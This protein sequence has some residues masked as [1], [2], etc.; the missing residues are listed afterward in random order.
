MKAIAFMLVALISTASLA[1]AAGPGRAPHLGIAV[2]FE[3]Q[4]DIQVVCAFDITDLESG[5]R[6]LAPRIVTQR[7]IDA[8]LTSTMSHADRDLDVEMRCHVDQTQAAYT[9]SLRDNGM[10]LLRQ[11]GSLD[12]EDFS[13]PPSF[14][15]PG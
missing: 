14:A 11:T 10:L 12:L 1:T 9:L 2:A 7:G 15:E 13:V 4:D 5:E 8:D 3:V 6:L